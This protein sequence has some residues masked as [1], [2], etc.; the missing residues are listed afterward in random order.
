MDTAQS[1]TGITKKNIWK[2]SSLGS[3]RF[4][5]MFPPGFWISQQ[6]DLRNHQGDAPEVSVGLETHFKLIQGGKGVPRK[7]RSSRGKVTWEADHKL[8]SL[9]RCSVK[10]LVGKEDPAVLTCQQHFDPTPWIN[11]MLIP[12][13]N[14]LPAGRGKRPQE[15]TWRETPFLRSKELKKR[16]DLTPARAG[17]EATGEATWNPLIQTSQNWQPDLQSSC[18]WRTPSSCWPPCWCDLKNSSNPHRSM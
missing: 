10:K 11:Q 18:W 16:F 15:F 13:S 17:S 7:Q 3:V 2:T 8:G 6:A 4:V 12:L 9:N 1:V 5:Q 14:N